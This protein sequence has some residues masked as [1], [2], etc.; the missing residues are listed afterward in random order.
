MDVMGAMRE[1]IALLG[2]TEDF[3]WGEEPGC[4]N[5]HL[6]GMLARMER[7]HL[8]DE[9]SY[10][11]MCRWLGWAQGV[12]VARGVATLDQTKEINRRHAG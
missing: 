12:I 4:S 9:M 2:D 6:R 8:T 10:G 11:K 7:R 3:V 5:E 1:T